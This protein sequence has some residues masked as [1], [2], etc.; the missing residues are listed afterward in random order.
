MKQLETSSVNR[1]L[2]FALS[3]VH[4]ACETLKV[5]KRFRGNAVICSEI[6]KCRKLLLKCSVIALLRQVT[7]LEGRLRYLL[8]LDNLQALPILPFQPYRWETP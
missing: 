6:R 4:H 5:L 7:R 2:P 1:S 8:L 3:P